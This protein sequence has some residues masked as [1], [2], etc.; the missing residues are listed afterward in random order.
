MARIVLIANPSASRVTPEVVAAVERVLVE[1]GRVETRLTEGRGHAVA[2]AEEASESA[3]L[4]FVLS[5]D[6]G[7]NEAVNGLSGDVPIGFLPGGGTSVL[8]RAL[9]LPRDPVS[10]ATGLHA[11]RRISL[12]RVNGRRFTVSGGLGLDADLVRRVDRL[13]RGSDGRRPGDAAYVRELL[14]HLVERRGVFGPSLMVEGLGRAAFALVANC[15][16][17]SYLGRVPLHVAPEARFEL[18]LDLVA[19]IRVGPPDV[20]RILWWLLARPAQSRSPDVLYAH[21]ADELRIVCDAPLP[22]Q[23]DGEDLGDITEAVFEAE[24]DALAVL[25]PGR[26]RGY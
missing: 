26:G 8:P 16:P 15:D 23:V 22:L 10:A 14:R 2:L 18:G 11:V 20:A 5:G 9:G 24:R 25:V 17:Y 13:G 4:V 21:D 19:P 12:G 7:Y 3:D 1:R 6:G